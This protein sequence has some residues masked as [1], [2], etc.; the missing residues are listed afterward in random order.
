M[1]SLGENVPANSPQSQSC[2]VQ[3]TSKKQQDH[4]HLG[5]Y[6]PL[7]ACNSTTYNNYSLFIWNA[8][9]SL[10]KASEQTTKELWNNFVW[11]TNHSTSAQ[12]PH[13]VNTGVEGW[14]FGLVYTHLTWS[15]CIEPWTPF[16]S[17]VL[18]AVWQLKPGQNWVMQQESDLNLQQNG[19]KSKEWKCWS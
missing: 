14:W 3:R 1:A 13:A 12:T 11:N 15:P 18:V 7:L 4:L 19:W 2:N 6:R 16:Y 8:R 10:K 17:K 9:E 5:L